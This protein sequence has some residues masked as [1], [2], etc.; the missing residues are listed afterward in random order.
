MPPSRRTTSQIISLGQYLDADF[1]PTSL[2]VPQMLGILLYHK[3]KYPTRY[4][5]KELVH[6]FNSKIKPRSAVF[7]NERITQE[8]V[9]GGNCGIKDGLTGLSPT[10]VR[11]YIVRHVASEPFSLRPTNHVFGRPS[12]K[13]P[14]VQLV[15]PG[16]EAPMDVDLEMEAGAD[17]DIMMEIDY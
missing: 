10:P 2:T 12:R 15:S 16:V 1:D 9:T 14:E 8:N 5:K 13:Q 3:V 17:I 6:I 7:K 11:S 4:S